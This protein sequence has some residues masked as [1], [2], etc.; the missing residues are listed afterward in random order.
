MLPWEGAILGVSWL[1]E[2]QCNV[3]GSGHW[4]KP[5]QNKCI[6]LYDLYVL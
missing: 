6:T 1:I 2:R 3:S 5:C 4:G